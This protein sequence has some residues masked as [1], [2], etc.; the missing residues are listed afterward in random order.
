MRRF[1]KTAAA[2]PAES[3]FAVHLDGKPIRTPAKRPLIVPSAAL[4]EAIAAEWAGQGS[5]VDPLSMPL[6]RLACT[7]I[8]RVAGNRD[9][10]VGD[11]AGYARTDLL[12]YRAGHPPD[13]AERQNAAWQPQPHNIPST[14]RC[15]TIPADRERSGDGLCNACY[16]HCIIPVRQWVCQDTYCTVRIGA[17]GSV[18]DGVWIPQRW[19]DPGQLG[20]K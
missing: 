10:V 18:Q 16:P 20:V 7:A 15:R 1:Y 6:M 3:G 11:L 13:L 19:V 2:A 9:A 12:C 4:A 17:Q 14:E 5:E 8:D